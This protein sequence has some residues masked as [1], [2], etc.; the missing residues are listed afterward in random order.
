M[1][2]RVLSGLA[3]VPL[4]LVFYFGGYWL[5]ALALIISVIGLKEF[6]NGFEN[7]DVHPNIKVGYGAIAVLYI[8]NAYMYYMGDFN[9]I[10]LLAWLVLVI[11]A[12]SLYMFDI[13]K[14][15]PVDAM[16]TSQGL[17]YVVFF[18]FH[19]VLVDQ[20]NV[21]S[22]MKWLVLLTAFGSDICAYFTGMLLGR[23]KLCPDLS[24]K[25]TIEGAI[26]GIIGSVAIGVA[27]GFIVQKYIP[28]VKLAPL[29]FG[30][31]CVFGAAA[32][33]VG[34][35]AASAI[36]RKVG[37]KDYGRLI[38]GHGGVLDR[39]DSVIMVA[40]IIFLITIYMNIVN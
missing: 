27:Y 21:Y 24:P 25:K 34:D 40:P 6:Y 1:K 22:D 10:F 37:I 28:D 2:T 16:A 30:I 32:S 39:F 23:H 9:N 38:P 5:M 36:K 4:L 3:M 8:M 15:R 7:M 31:I 19:V 14:V 29:I 33:Q 11:M 13:K 12:G 17:I 18:A 20:L 26:G 35:L